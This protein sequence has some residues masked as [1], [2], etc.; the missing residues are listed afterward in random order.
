M[1]ATHIDRASPSPHSGAASFDCR[2]A[3]VRSKSDTGLTVISIGGEIDAA[4]V[5]DVHHHVSTLGSACGALI[6]D[7]ADVDFIAL[8]G[9]R[10][11][12]A[13]DMQ[14]ARTETTFVLIVSHAVSRLLRWGDRDKLLP[15]VGSATEALLLIR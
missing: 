4:N 14:C 8:A 11:L 10:A 12:F 15:V 1:P 5:A 3:W 7:L 9:L 2:G 13:L 6:V